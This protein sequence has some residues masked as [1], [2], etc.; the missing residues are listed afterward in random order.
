VARRRGITGLAGSVAL[1]AGMT[2]GVVGSAAGGV[3]PVATATPFARLASTVPFVT[4]PTTVKC[5]RTIGL[6]CYSPLQ[7]QT[8]YDMKPLY[9]AGDTGAGKTIV[10]VDSFG[11]P[12]IGSDLKTFDRGF[13]LP[14]PPS[15]TVLQPDGPVPPFNPANSTMIGWAEE[16]S[17]DVEYSH[18]MAPGANIL[19]VETPVAETE[20]VVGFPQIV[21]AEQ[22]VLNHH[23]GD[24]IS[25]SFGATEETFPSAAALMALRGAYVQ[26]A[27]D[28]VTVLAGSGDEG[29]TNAHFNGVTFFTHRV[30]SWPSTD[31]LVTSVGGTQLHLTNTG[32]RLLPDNVWNDTN[33]LGSL[34]ASGGGLSEFFSRPSY[35]NGVSSVVGAARG[36]PDVAL[37]AAVDGSA[38]VYMSFGGLPIPAY[39]LVGGTSEA[40]PLFAGIVA[41]ADQVA[42]HD[43]GLLNPQ[44]YALSASKAPGIVD[45]TTGN[46]T[47]T[48]SQNAKTYT[49]RGF[50]AVPGYDLASG[51]GT[52][53]GAQLVAELAGT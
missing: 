40:T 17:L 7:Y 16:T 1:V 37:S 42:G 47:V 10:I 6:A 51:V 41:I 15:F 39:Y 33:L 14:A 53:D 9:R 8:A 35:Q 50:E 49:V 45:I 5:D 18:A 31:P 26:A 38:L 52:V 48:F 13:G 28:N 32:Q 29:S 2:F 46:N 19:L 11:S 4:P 21:A 30:N 24:V 23:L 25:Q 12:T 43:L 34:A 20:G 44:L 22:Y 3:G 27:A 36:T